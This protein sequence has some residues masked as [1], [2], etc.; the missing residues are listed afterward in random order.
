VDRRLHRTGASPERERERLRAGIEELDL[1]QAIAHRALL[2]HELDYEAA[3]FSRRAA[4][5][6]RPDSDEYCTP[7]DANRPA[8]TI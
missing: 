7:R 8:S 5:N 1:E 4:R 2:P 6:S 3:S